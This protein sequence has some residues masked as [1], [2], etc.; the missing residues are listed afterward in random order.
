M[1]ST[2]ANSIITAIIIDVTLLLFTYGLTN[3]DLFYTLKQKE[4]K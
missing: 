2:T 4:N 3:Y 1:T